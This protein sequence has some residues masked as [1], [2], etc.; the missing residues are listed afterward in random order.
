MKA[1]RRGPAPV[2]RRRRPE[3]SRDGIAEVALEG[4][5][6][7]GSAE[8]F[9]G[10]LTAATDAGA[11]VVLVTL[12]T[13]G[14]CLA[15]TARMV[16]AVKAFPGKVIAFVPTQCNSAG[17]LVML[18]ADYVLMQPGSEVV[19]H[20]PSGDDAEVVAAWR[21][22]ILHTYEA[23]TG[24]S[25]MQAREWFN[26]GDTRLDA[27]AALSRHFIDDAGDRYHARAVAEQF[28]AGRPPVSSRQ[29][30]RAIKR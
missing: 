4:R 23:N 17:T 7:D 12:T 21:E 13:E 16:D 30:V 8:A 9:I 25:D 6:D 2:S 18:A 19:I 3:V 29:V 27:C 22:A 14:G 11:R 26:S 20:G 15:S 28:A 1:R 24:V 5:I 10:E